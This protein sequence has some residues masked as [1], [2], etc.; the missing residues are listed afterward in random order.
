MTFPTSLATQA[1][2]QKRAPNI[3]SI[4]WPDL[5][6]ADE[7][8]SEVALQFLEQ[9]DLFRIVEL[10]QKLEESIVKGSEALLKLDLQGIEDGTREQLQLLQEFAEVR[11]QLAHAL[12]A[13]SSAKSSPET[14]QQG[15]ADARL[16]KAAALRVIHATRLQLALLARAQR[17]L[18]VVAHMLAGPG[19][20]YPPP[21]HGAARVAGSDSCRA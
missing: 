18:R 20:C 2:R 3:A 17:K 10:L 9:A 13:R 8:F 1:T 11:P 15:T 7:S 4:A 19:A 12:A 6:R 14:A 5:M 16:V 21:S